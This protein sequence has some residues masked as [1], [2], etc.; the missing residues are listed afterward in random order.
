MDS[1]GVAGMIQGSIGSMIIVASQQV[2][3]WACLLF[4]GLSGPGLTVPDST[5]HNEF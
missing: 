2:T 4:L 1:S 5:D 3:L